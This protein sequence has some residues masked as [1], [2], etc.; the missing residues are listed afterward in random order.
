MASDR[1]GDDGEL[2]LFSFTGVDGVLVDS[3]PGFVFGA[4]DTLLIPLVGE[5]IISCGS[6]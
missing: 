4:N 2:S 5:V 6:L 3:S 1:R